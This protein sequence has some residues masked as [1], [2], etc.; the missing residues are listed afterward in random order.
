VQAKWLIDRYCT[1]INDVDWILSFEEFKARLKYKKKSA[2]G[3]DGL[4]YCAYAHC[5]D[6]ILRAL[7]KLYVHICNGGELDDSFNEAFMVFLAKGQEAGDHM[8]I[9]RKPS[10]TRPLSLSNCDS[11]LV[12]DALASKIAEAADAAVD[13]LQRA[14]F[15][16][17]NMVG[18]I[19]EV[20]V[21]A[22]IAAMTSSS[23]PCLALWD[24][25]A[26]FPSLEHEFLW[27]VLE[28]VGFPPMIILA[29]Q[30]LYQHNHHTIILGRDR[31]SRF[32]VTRGVKQG[33]P[34]SMLL[35]CIALNVFTCFVKDHMSP[36]IFT[37]RAFADD[38]AMIFH[39]IGHI[40]PILLMFNIWGQASGLVL[41]MAKCV[42]V[43]LWADWTNDEL[44]RL[45]ARIGRG[46]T[47]IQVAGWGKYLGIAIGPGAQEH[48]WDECTKKFVQRVETIRN[49]GIGLIGSINLYSMLAVSV[50]SYVAAFQE[51]SRAVLRRE[52]FAI[53]KITAGP[54][55]AIPPV[56]LKHGKNAGLPLQVRCV[57]TMSIAARSRMANVTC[58][59][60]RKI[61]KEQLRDALHVSAERLLMPKH[62]TLQLGPSR[63]QATLP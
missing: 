58:V 39:D 29:I 46:A 31:H 41:N 17:R 2:P 50:L 21:A 9:S 24:F 16:G 38:L 40:R 36:S 10:H 60:V 11:K 26:A 54:C 33:C 13:A 12:A 61:L 56:L 53:N 57:R 34:M 63:A 48:A 27:M 44:Q 59:E 23:K 18:N 3:P 62:T 43:P 6:F 22:A 8:E 7:Y 30:H 37:M 55:H 28:A 25:T 5:P 42:V 4:P 15:K 49:L 52:Y 20:E 47:L 51:P 14:G 1:R 19:L 32:T 45:M 35:F